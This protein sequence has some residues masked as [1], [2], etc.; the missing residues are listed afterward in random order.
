MVKFPLPVLPIWW[1]HKWVTIKITSLKIF[2]CQKIYIIVYSWSPSLVI[3]KIH[4]IDL[5]NYSHSIS[6]MRH[7]CTSIV[8]VIGV[9]HAIGPRVQTPL[10]LELIWYVGTFIIEWYTLWKK[11]W[12]VHDNG[13]NW[14]IYPILI[15]VLV[16]LHNCI[17]QVQ[18]SECRSQD[19]YFFWSV[20]F[21]VINISLV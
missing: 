16:S 1:S 12:L 9:A 4:K 19:F 13:G 3:C 10:C 20:W 7:Q 8:P 17:V 2:M 6:M 18:W 5:W 21:Q 15:D 14:S 11:T